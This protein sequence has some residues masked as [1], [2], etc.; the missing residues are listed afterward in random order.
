MTDLD[1]GYVVNFWSSLGNHIGFCGGYGFDYER[2]ALKSPVINQTGTTKNQFYRSSNVLFDGFFRFTSASQKSLDPLPRGL[3][4]DLGAQY[5][6]PIVFQYVEALGQGERMIKNHIHQFRDFRVYSN[7]G[8]GQVLLF[9]EYR[10]L[11]FVLGKFVEMPKFNG[12]I[13]FSIGTD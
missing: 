1:I 13:R 7:I 8:F 2:Y 11:D 5:K 9:A 10:P 12:G 4:W 3:V 6:L